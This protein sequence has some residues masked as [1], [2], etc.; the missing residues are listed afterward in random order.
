M[1]YANIKPYDIA[2]GPGVRV[3]LFVSGCTHHCEGC[4]N[5]E[6]WDF[7]FGRPYNKDTEDEIMNYL[8]RPF[9]QGITFLGGEPME[10]ENQGDVLNLIKRVR[11]DLPSRDIWLYSGYTLET[12][13]LSGK[14]SEYKSTY[15]ILSNIDVLVDGEFILEKKDISLVFRGSSNQRVIDM[16]KTLAD[17]KTR[18]C[19]EYI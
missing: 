3:S 17:G 5:S 9:I 6:A 19:P 7:S 16:K 13:M 1:N 11:K 4:F 8:A 10:P 14:L 15:E 18:L 12:D 2:D